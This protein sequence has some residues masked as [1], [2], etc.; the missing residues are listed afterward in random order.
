MYRIFLKEVQSFFSSLVGYVVIG[1]FLVIL[2]L[3]MWVFPDTSIL[4]YK[5]ATLETLFSMAPF[6]FTFLVPAITM[7]SLAEEKQTGT[8]EMLA[9]KPISDLDIILGKF[10]ASVLL[11]IFA[12]LPTLIYYYTVYQLGS[13]VGNLDSGAVMGSYLG[14]ILLGAAFTS[15]GIFASSLSKNQISAFILATFLCFFLYWGFFYISKLPIFIGKTDDLVQKAGIEYHYLSISRGL[16]DTRDVSYFI[17]V[18]GIF[19][20]LSLLS[21]KARILEGSVFNIKDFSWKEL[22]VGALPSILFFVLN[23]SIG[24]VVRLLLSLLLIVPAVWAVYL[25]KKSGNSHQIVQP[26]IAIAIFAVMM[27]AGN[28]LYTNFDLTEEKRFTLTD[29]TKKLLSEAKDVIF[30]QVLFRR[31]LSACKQRPKKCSMTFGPLMAWSSTNFPIPIQA[32][33]K[34]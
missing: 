2:G 20:M 6:I 1:V 15:M 30:V 34:K 19:I 11:L 3:V 4:H 21:L 8:I 7:R 23:P 32:A 17:A 25:V 14:L 18:I 31:D 12:L 26:I 28:Y 24:I 33:L 27:V 29:P 22:A 16:V 9:T 10:F 13:P 5:Y